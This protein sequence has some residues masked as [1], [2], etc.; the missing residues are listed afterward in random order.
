MFFYWEINIFS[1]QEHRISCIC[2][3]SAQGLLDVNYWPRVSGRWEKNNFVTCTG[4]RA[5]RLL[6]SCLILRIK[7]S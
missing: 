5:M 7:S 6:F 4:Q 1:L 2:I 3:L